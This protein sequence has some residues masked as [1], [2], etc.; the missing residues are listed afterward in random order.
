MV[1]VGERNRVCYVHLNLSAL[2]PVT[3]L[4]LHPLGAFTTPAFSPDGYSESLANTHQ[5]RQQRVRVCV[6]FHK[7][8]ILHDKDLELGVRDH[9]Q[10]TLAKS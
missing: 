6:C 7:D 5:Q 2:V 3:N 1:R 10:K 4:V 8:S 9:T